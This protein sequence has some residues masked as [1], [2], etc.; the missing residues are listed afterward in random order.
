MS[1][2]KWRRA[3][4]SVCSLRL[5]CCEES[6]LL[7]TFAVSSLWFCC[8]GFSV[9]N[10]TRLM[11]L[12]HPREASLTK[13]QR[14]NVHS[15]FVSFFSFKRHSN[16]HQDILNPSSFW[17]LRSAAASVRR[18]NAVAKQMEEPHRAALTPRH[19]TFPSWW[20]HGRHWHSVIHYKVN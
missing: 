4:P 1:L 7:C 13:I 15:I 14:H 10:F 9:C 12:S 19:A 20:F 17:L 16:Q 18:G 8:S 2:F 3:L 11:T 6:G 5:Q